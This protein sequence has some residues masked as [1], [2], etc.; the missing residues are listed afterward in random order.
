LH[1]L[2]EALCVKLLVVIVLFGVIHAV[3]RLGHGDGNRR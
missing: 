1:P 3:P 2:Y